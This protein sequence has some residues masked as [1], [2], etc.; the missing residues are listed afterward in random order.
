V[1]AH[2]FDGVRIASGQSGTPNL[3]RF[4]KP[5][6]VRLSEGSRSKSFSR[7]LFLNSCLL[8]PHLFAGRGPLTL[9]GLSY[10]AARRLPQEGLD[11]F[12]QRTG[13]AVNVLPAW[14]NST[15]QLAVTRK[16]LMR[17]FGTPDVYVIDVIWPGSLGENLLDLTSYL[18]A[19]DRGH[20]PELLANDTVNGRLVS[21][22]FYLN[23]GMLYY[24]TDLLKKYG[25]RQPPQTWGEMERMAARIQQGE[26]RAGHTEFWGYVWQGSPYEGLT[27]NAL[28]WQVSFGGGRL[29]ESDGVVSVNNPRAA[30]ALRMA[31]RWVGSISPPSVLS[32]NES[33]SLNAFRS[34]S[35]AF[36]RYWSSGYSPA[37]PDDS[38]VRGRFN[39]TLLPAGPRGRAQTMG[40]F[41]IAVSRYSVHL[42]ESA[43]L[44]SF[45]TGEQVQKRRAV[46][47][48]YLPT[49]PDL[50]ND[51]DLLKAIPQ[52]QALRKSGLAD[53]VSRPSAVTGNEY[54][55][56]SRAYYG[57]VHAVLRHQIQPEEALG[58]LE[59]QL[60]ELLRSAHHFRK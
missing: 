13:I 55:D 30:A 19:N 37:T 14:G 24:R 22:P 52:A 60:T 53:W 29:V 27:C 44:A 11:D 50:Y 21:L 43:E 10:E 40:G 58:G 20:L 49:R 7:R 23:I 35:A 38:A 28:E 9:A 56:V 32:Y 46:Q 36:M 25:Y 4:I 59:K 15:D 47:G 34:G 5:A 48:G 12:T 26:R 57:A 6:R 2:E 18:T 8:P 51:P 54:A 42:R 45:L 39:V 41:Q 16:T 33:D 1:C 3:T 17:H 31:T